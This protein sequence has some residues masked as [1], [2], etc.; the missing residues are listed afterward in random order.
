MNTNFLVPVS[1]AFSLALLLFLLL[2]VP[3]NAQ[4]VDPSSQIAE[5]ESTRTGPASTISVDHEYFRFDRTF[6]PWHLTSAAITARTRIGSVI[7][8]VNHAR[9]F[10]REGT[11]VELDAYPKLARGVYAYV[12]GGYAP[13]G[14]FPEWRAGGEVF[15]SL[16]GSWESSV[17]ARWLQFGTRDVVIYTGSVGKYVGNYWISARPFV[18]PKENGT[19]ASATVTARRYFSDR[20]DYVGLSFGYGSSP[21]D[22]VL[23]EVDLD[24]NESWKMG[25]EGERPIVAPLRLTW[26]LSYDREAYPLQD[27]RNRLGLKLGLERDF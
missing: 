8:R 13:D 14:L 26:R 7:G 4:D 17:G 5:V 6:S 3:L 1:V 19:S 25:L 18:T 23:A 9:R 16:P 22:E 10:G 24:H 21:A 11:Q 27:P 12:N 15:G 20:N 2:V